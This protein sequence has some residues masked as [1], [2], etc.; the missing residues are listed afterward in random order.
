M[1]IPQSTYRLQFHADFNLSRLR[2]ILDYLQ[3]LGIS[4]VYASPILAA[5]LG[6]T[7]G[8]DVID[9]LQI[10]PEIGTE[11]ALTEIA[12]ELRKRNIGWI[13]DIVPNHM[14]FD[15]ANPWITSLLELGP[16]SPYFEH[17]DVDWWNEH[18]DNYGK[19]MLPIL[20]ESLTSVLDSD[21]LRLSFDDLGLA[22]RY[23]ENRIPL[24]AASYTGVLT[25]IIDQTSD[26]EDKAQFTRL[27]VALEPFALDIAGAANPDEWH[28]FKNQWQDVFLKDKF[29]LTLT[30]AIEQLNDNDAF[31]Q[32]LLDKQHFRLVYWKKTE[33][34]IY[35][36]RF[37]TV[38]DLICLNMQNPT[39][40]D[41]YHQLLS[42]LIQKD[43]IQGLRIDH[44]DGLFDPTQYL[45]RLRNLVGSDTYLVVEKILEEEEV[46]PNEWP[47]QGTTGY[48]F[49]VQVNRFF[50]SSTQSDQLSKLYRLWEPEERSY[51]DIVYDNK[52][53]IFRERMQGELNNLFR[54]LET[55]K[56]IPEA[57]T[58]SS[59]ELQAALAHMLVAFPV[60][61]I[62][63]NQLPLAEESLQLLG[64]IF[65]E[66]QNKAPQLSAAFDTLRAI[67]NGVP[68]K[69][70]EV[71]KN[72]LYFIQRCQQFSGPL[73]AKGIEDTTFYQYYRL[74]S[75]NEVGDNPDHLGMITNELHQWLQ[76][77]SLL[78][79]NATSTHD[80]KRGEDAR[81]RINTLSEQVDEW[82]KLSTKWK[83]DHRQYCTEVAGKCYPTNND[84]YFVYQ[85]LVGTYPFHISPLEDNYT[86]RLGNYLEKAV[87]EGKANT[88][89]SS[90]NAD[91]EKSLADFT[92]S[93]L[94]NADFLAEL[95]DFAQPLARKSVTY[96]LGQT[97]LKAM[98][99]GVPDIY[100]GTE[101]WDL[102]MVDPDNRRPVDY[103][104]RRLLLEQFSQD[105]DTLSQARQLIANPDDPAIKM[106]TLYHSLQ[107]RKRWPALF[108]ESYY[109]PLKVTGK[110]A[111]HVLAFLRRHQDRFVL[112]VIPRE[113]IQ[114]LSE[115]SYFLLGAQWEDT[116]VAIPELP[117][118]FWRH[119]FTGEIVHRSETSL[120]ISAILQH[121]P[122][123][124]L[125][126]QQ[127]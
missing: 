27:L 19:L 60:Y 114:L 121:F 111:A 84:V 91:Y 36:R 44:V 14:A 9:P 94:S 126:N 15:P 103:S 81:I 33:R 72:T 101:F 37:F 124:I 40:F 93:I 88:N 63:D 35:Y 24:S 12:E 67:F 106:Y 48:D 112:V 57:N 49:L 53:F 69:S 113:V 102:S 23:Y 127:S 98:A 65:S 125:T 97:V 2:D 54:S 47:I 89:W 51:T 32:E 18:P 99:P 38:N 71:N 5:R 16:R 13:Q 64:K 26:P 6:S 119:E 62:Y 50:S 31:I 25:N 46:I 110:Y 117:A 120:P 96:S 78:T 59:E 45:E 107:L 123:A 109:Q 66:A 42:A 75:R 85:T 70:E 7:H 68:D 1:Y 86:E 87:R 90:P 11:A 41:D 82:T 28:H 4:T 122:I 95:T 74:I 73:A 21:Q 61:R 34:E 8:Y 39:V 79:M 30:E 43:I 115:D 17:F 29:R 55:L 56:I 22:V 105:S 77:R 3:A 80:T 83:N 20:G 92:K 104:A 58:A 100:Q 76:S 116:E 52:M 118:G 10:N 108:A